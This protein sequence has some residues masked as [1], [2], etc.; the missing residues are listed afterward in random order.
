MTTFSAYVDATRGDT[1]LERVDA[2]FW[3][4][5]VVAEGSIA[6]SPGHKGKMAVIDL[7]ARRGRIEDILGLFV[8]ERRAPMSGPTSLKARVEIPSG[9]K[10]FLEKVRLRGMFGVDEGS[11]TKPQRQEDVNKLSA[12]ARGEPKD[13]AE[14]VLSELTGSVGLENGT[15]RFSDLSFSV[16]GAVA[17]MHGDYNIINHKIDLHGT[18]KVD[19]KISKT[20]TGMKAL[21][22]KMID[23]FFKKKRK[24]EIVPVHIGGTYEHPQF[25]LDLAPKKGQPADSNPSRQ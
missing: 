7:E 24:G 1:Y 5:H 15:A 4:T 17:R 25:G 9:N 21:M 10:P 11:F 3:R 12:G 8:K 19:S 6:G 23:P 20:T 13:D 2:H 14:T 22:L 16:P 18:M